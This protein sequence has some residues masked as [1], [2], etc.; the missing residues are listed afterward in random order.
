MQRAAWLRESEEGARMAA[1]TLAGGT[2]AL[3][4]DLT[5]TR[6]G[7][8]SMQLAGPQ[9][10]GPPADRDEV[11]KTLRRAP[12]LGVDLIDF[13]TPCD[14]FFNDSLDGID[15]LSPA[16]VVQRQDGRQPFAVR[17]GGD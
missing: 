9:V 4:G 12:E 10:F 2:F 1:K 5:V 16:T 11:L 8:G 13:H 6:M 7:Y 15:D 3:G 17:S 14:H